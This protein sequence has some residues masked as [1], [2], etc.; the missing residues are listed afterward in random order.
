MTRKDAAATGNTPMEQHRKQIGKQDWKKSKKDVKARKRAADEQS[1]LGI[2]GVLGVLAVLLALLGGLYGF[3][4]WYIGDTSRPSE[5][6][7]T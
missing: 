3:L 1:E 7:P 6:T 4:Y 2:M 5:Q